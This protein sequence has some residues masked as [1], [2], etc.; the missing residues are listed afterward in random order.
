MEVEQSGWHDAAK[1]DEVHKMDEGANLENASAPVELL[2]LA[3]IGV[4]GVRETLTEILV[5]VEPNFT[6]SGSSKAVLQDL[7]PCISMM[8]CKQLFFISDI[9]SSQGFLGF[10][11]L[12]F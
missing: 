6:K 11:K 8:S 10:D 9:T 3:D 1:S 12:L 7:S 4:G 5:D 2:G